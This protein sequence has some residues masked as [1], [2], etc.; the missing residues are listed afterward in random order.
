METSFFNISYNDE[1]SIMSDICRSENIPLFNA[2]AAAE[3]IPQAE[4]PS[5]FY[6]M[7]M[8]AKGHEY[9]ASKLYPFLF[10]LSLRGQ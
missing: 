10:Q 7:H 4:R 8:N 6:L 5:M 3:A 9:L 1:I 2:E